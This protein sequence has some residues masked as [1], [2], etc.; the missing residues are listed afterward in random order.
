MVQSIVNFV[1]A[2]ANKI[3]ETRVKSTG[4]VGKPKT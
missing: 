2:I 4:L 3:T 1:F